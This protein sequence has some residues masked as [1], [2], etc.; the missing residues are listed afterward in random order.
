LIGQQNKKW[1]VGLFVVVAT[2]FWPGYAQAQWPPF[3]FNIDSIFDNG[4][5]IYRLELSETV[6]WPMADVIFKV[7]LPAGTRYVESGAPDGTTAN[8]DGAEITFLTPTLHGSLKDAYFIVEVIDPAKTEYAAHAW[9]SWKGEVPG[10][11]LTDDSVIDITRTPLVW[12]KPW[13]RLRL[14]AGAVVNGN[15]ITYLL[16]PVNTGGRR[17]WDLSI[18]LPLPAGVTFVSAEA[19]P[20][21]TA[22]F[23]GQQAVFFI[24]ELERGVRV[25]PL[26]VKVTV[27]ENTSPFLV[28]QA[29]AGWTNVGNNVD[30]QEF[31][32][33]GEIIVQPQTTQYVVADSI[34]DV[35]FASYDLT[36]ITFQQDGEAVKATFYT[37]EPMG[38]VG[39]PIEHYLYLDSDCN[40]DTGKPRGN[41]GAEYWVRYRHQSGRG[42]IYTWDPAQSAWTNRQ[43]IPA[44]GDSGNAASVWVP[45]AVIPA[46]TAMCWLAVSRNLTDEYHPVPPVDWLGRDARLTA[47][48][49]AP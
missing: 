9:I 23:D 41:R 26:Q 22:G 24:N 17:M 25:D 34:G 29:T 46:E 3:N 18:N 4:K 35:P 13:S 45:A 20:P 44:Y 49:T 28:T 40:A 1:I 38:A 48:L 8:F 47:G 15:E 42:Y 11:F 21:F 10:D 19:P 37:A 30:P 33:T 12:D 16:Y 14:E 27:A 32:K 2:I 5:I 43:Q 7:P 6:G 39:Q 31:T 36:G